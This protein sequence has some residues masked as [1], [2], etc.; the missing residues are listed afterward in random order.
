MP[1]ST[2]SP[3]YS[4]AIGS[5]SLPCTF[6]VVRAVAPQGGKHLLLDEGGLPFLDDQ[7]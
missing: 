3:V 1:V 4:P 2:T 6:D 5:R 7:D